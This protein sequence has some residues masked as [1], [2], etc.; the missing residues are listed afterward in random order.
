MGTIDGGLTYQVTPNF[1]I[2]VNAFVGVTESAD[3][4]NVFTGFAY[5]F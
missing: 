4:L 3:D 2:D 1:S 5:R